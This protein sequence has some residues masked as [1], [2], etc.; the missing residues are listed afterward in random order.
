MITVGP[1]FKDIFPNENA[2]LQNLLSGLPR[3][4]VIGCISLINAHLFRKE[5]NDDPDISEDL[6]QTFHIISVLLKFVDPAQRGITIQNI[7]AFC[8]KEKL[9]GSHVQLFTQVNCVRF[10]D[11]AI[12][13]LSDDNSK[14][15]DPKIDDLNIFKAFI[16]FNDQE[17]NKIERLITESSITSNKFENYV[18]YFWPVAFMQYEY[19]KVKNP[20][21]HFFMGTILLIYLSQHKILS[22]DVLFFVEKRGCKTVLEY[23]FNILE[24][25]PA[26]YNDNLD[27]Y[28][29]ACIHVGE[30][31]ASVYK[32]LQI[33]LDEYK[34]SK[35]LQTAYKGIKSKPLMFV[36][37]NVYNVLDW[38]MLARKAN[39]ALLFDV[40]LDTDI[41]KSYS[42]FADFKSLE[43]GKIVENIAAH[44]LRYI[45][46]SKGVIFQAEITSDKL[47]TPDVYIRNGNRIYLVEVKSNIASDELKEEPTLEKIKKFIDERINTY[48]AKGVKPKGS[49]QLFEIVKYL[50]DNEFEF[51]RFQQRGFKRK[52]IKI[53]PIVIAADDCFNINGV[54]Q[55][56]NRDFEEK[57]RVSNFE[58][59]VKPITIITIDLLV[60]EMLDLKGNGKIHELFDKYHSFSKEQERKEME[61]LA[62]NPYEPFENYF[63]RT[64]KARNHLY[65]RDFFKAFGIQEYANKYLPK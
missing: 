6:N 57:I 23:T 14:V 44:A 18:A 25:Y 61:S 49:G 8:A 32:H 7:A 36:E 60:G 34:S 40:F 27:V 38:N 26:F 54:N 21:Y 5:K 12:R 56:I 15:Y 24:I 13:N 62:Q 46:G 11:Y 9:L 52:N 28:Q 47:S 63:L 4:G 2:D 65:V 29:L 41:K 43:I 31:L 37:D 50:D 42:T 39:D 51:D 58:V 30:K 48:R 35:Q 53:Y 3:K 10:I 17:F 55:Y 45:V 59:D 19:V 64:K 20:V 1:S 33:D 22:K 16:L